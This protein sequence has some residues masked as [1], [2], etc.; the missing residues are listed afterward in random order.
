MVE[1]LG[2][3]WGNAG[4]LRDVL[5]PVYAVSQPARVDI[6]EMEY[7]R[8][9]DYLLTDDPNGSYDI[10]CNY[11]RYALAGDALDAML[12]WMTRWPGGSVRPD[13]M[14]ILFAIGGA[15]GDRT[16]DA[17]AYVHRGSNFLFE[18][19]ANW[20][21]M[22]SPA[23]VERQQAWLTAYQSDMQRFVQPRSYVN[24]PN[25][26]LQNWASA[27]YGDNLPRL[28]KI[29]SKYDASNLFSFQQSIPLAVT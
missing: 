12:G 25:R 28:S 29:K 19:E 15:V 7:W 17:T 3:F 6:Y 8:A 1:T 4:E 5:A 10:R 22:D 27:Y 16:P 24:F 21:P 2:L 13:N 23:I 20:S 11:V 26:M 14:G 18:M 9:R